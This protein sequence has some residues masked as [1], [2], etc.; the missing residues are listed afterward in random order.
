MKSLKRIR[1]RKHR[2][3]ELAMTVMLEEP[4]ADK[5][6]LV[7]GRIHHGIPHAWIETGDGRVYEPVQG[8]YMPV[9]E[10]DGVYGIAQRRYTLDAAQFLAWV[11]YNDNCA[12]HDRITAAKELMDRGHGKLQQSIEILEPP[13]NQEDQFFPGGFPARNRAPRLQE[14]DQFDT[15]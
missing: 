1:D 4:G 2:C 5:F 13:V 8:S 7:H 3:F 11:M 15:K 9:A 6:T 10:F 14:R 12:I